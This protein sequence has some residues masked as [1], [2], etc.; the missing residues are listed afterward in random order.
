MSDVSSRYRK[1]ADQFGA[2]VDAVPAAAWDNPTPCEGWVA[3]DI[4]RHMAE[5]MPALFLASVGAPLPELPPVDADPAATWRALDQALQAA[6]DDPEVATRQV[7]TPVGAF[8]VTDAIG[9]FG[10]SDVL[11]HTWD[12][13]R[14]TGLDEALDPAEVARLLDGLAEV[15]DALEQSGHYGPRV[16]V[17]DDADDQTRALALMGRGP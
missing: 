12:L 8:S 1:V 16:P 10:L 9:Q 15:G 2:R 5:W 11:V 6:L 17:P 4:V 7:T 3:R 13:A 14:A